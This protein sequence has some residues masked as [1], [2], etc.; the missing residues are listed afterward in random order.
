MKKGFTLIEILIC[1]SIVSIISLIGVKSL[2]TYLSLY[3][4][5]SSCTLEEFYVDQAFIFI[6]QQLGEGDGI[7]IFKNNNNI[8]E[9][10]VTNND[11]CNYIKLK[12]ERLVIAYDKSDSRYNNTIMYGVKEF[13]VEGFKNT[14]YVKIT[15]KY[16]KEYERCFGIRK[17]KE[18]SLYIFY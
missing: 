10:K 1:I 14:M 13:L 16:G 2:I 7:E 6:E 8:N 15:T 12:N 17:E 9:I 4:K 5:E 3:R 11:R 18:L